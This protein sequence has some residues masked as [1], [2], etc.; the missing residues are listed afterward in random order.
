MSS[1]VV[2]V[3]VAVAGAS[4]TQAAHHNALTNN[5]R[6]VVAQPH[7]PYRPIAPF[8]LT[9]AHLGDIEG[10]LFSTSYHGSVLYC[11]VQDLP[12]D[13]PHHIVFDVRWI[14]SS[15]AQGVAKFRL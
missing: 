11:T 1:L 12:V 10:Q 13:M 5:H 14:G 7:P 8:T 6:T 4:M 3:A 15:P 9:V 2:A